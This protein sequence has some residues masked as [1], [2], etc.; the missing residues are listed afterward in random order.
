MKY[1][2][3]KNDLKQQIN[4]GAI[5]PGSKLPSI[6]ELSV[7][8]KCSK[9]TVIR[10]IDELEKEHLIYSV[11]KSGYY[12]I[13]RPS[14]SEGRPE[15]RIDFA[16]ASPDPGII[17]YEE[18]G[19]GLNRAVQLYGDRLFTYGDPLGFLSLRETISQHMAVSQIF[20]EPERICI[21]SGSQ[22]ALHLLASMPFPNGKSAILV[23]QPCYTGMLRIMSLLGVTPIGIAR[24]ESGLDLDELERHFRNNSIKFFYTVPRYHNPLGTSLSR[25]E[26]ETIASL[27]EKYDVYIVEDDYLADLETDSKADPICS[28]DHSGRVIYIRSFSKIMLPGL[29]LGAAVLPASL[30]TLF[31]MY[32]S[33]SDLSTSALSQA[34]LEIH[35][36]SGLFQRHAARMRDRYGIR[37]KALQKA[38]SQYLNEG[39]RLS[40]SAGGIFAQLELPD[41][42][43]AEELAAALRQK[44]VYVFPT[45]QCYLPS[46]ES[47]NSWRLSI[48]RTNELEI[49]HGIRIIR[50]TADELMSQRRTNKFS[51]SAITWI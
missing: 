37:M 29:R 25:L 30:I 11:P 31:R 49:E 36:G 41:H 45:M 1:E 13:V 47:A 12:V 32:K 7:Q 23:E 42:L 14:K 22:Q 33:S 10:A 35:L 15:G 19:H 50:Q 44:D 28:Y 6:R 9:N 21:V 17:P 24:T 46:M 40:K 4:S 18:I 43:V 26:K 34:A 48:I 2:N 27:A 51:R 5:K 20:A 3:V 39:F 16:A 8:W 38:C